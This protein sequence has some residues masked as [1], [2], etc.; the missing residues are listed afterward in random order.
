MWASVAVTLGLSSGA[1]AQL[2]LGRWN[3]PG[4][5]IKLVSP[6]LAVR[7]PTTGPPVKS[8]DIFYIKKAGGKQAIRCTILEAR[9]CGEPDPRTGAAGHVWEV[10]GLPSGGSWHRGDWGQGGCFTLHCTQDGPLENGWSVS[11]V[12]SWGLGETPML[13]VEGCVS[14]GAPFL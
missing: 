2:A 5:G 7:L 9:L 8:R 11:V 10:C 13:V 12:P 14:S 3:L 1:W 6:T 4:P